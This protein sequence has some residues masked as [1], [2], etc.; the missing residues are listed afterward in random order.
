MLDAI[1]AEDRV[2][3]G[4]MQRRFHRRPAVAIHCRCAAE[5]GEALDH[6]NALSSVGKRSGGR[7]P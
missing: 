3:V 5:I 2:A 4:F 6:K 1:G 7:N